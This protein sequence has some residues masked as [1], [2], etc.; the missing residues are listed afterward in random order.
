MEN[1][2]QQKSR[3]MLVRIPACTRLQVYI[4]TWNQA[5]FL[6]IRLTLTRQMVSVKDPDSSDS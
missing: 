1:M 4:N 3:S 2:Y 6:S 5:E